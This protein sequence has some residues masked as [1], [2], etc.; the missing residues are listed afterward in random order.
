MYMVLIFWIVMFS[1]SLLF[2]FEFLFLFMK[3]YFDRRMHPTSVYPTHLLLSGYFLS[4]YFNLRLS[5]SWYLLRIGVVVQLASYNFCDDNVAQ[6]A[7]KSLVAVFWL[8][9]WTRSWFL[10]FFFTG[11]P[12]FFA[13]R[14]CRGRSAE[15]GRSSRWCQWRCVLRS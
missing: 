12:R 14:S 10:R 13:V 11:S 5:T 2:L 9:F 15:N 1:F 4:R 8:T 7:R 3:I 6:F